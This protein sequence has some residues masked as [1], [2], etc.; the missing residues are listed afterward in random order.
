MICRVCNKY[1]KGKGLQLLLAGKVQ[2][3]GFCSYKCYLK[4]WAKVPNFEPL[5]EAKI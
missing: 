3:T 2:P 5:P 1:K 4:F